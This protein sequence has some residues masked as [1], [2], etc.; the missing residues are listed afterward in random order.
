L[1]VLVVPMRVRLSRKLANRLDGI[2]VSRDP[3]GALLDLPVRQAELL[4]AE[5]WATPAERR[6]LSV[7]TPREAAGDHQ[8]RRRSDVSERRRADGR[9]GDEVP[10]TVVT[11]PRPRDNKSR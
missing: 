4:I 5:G 2:D 6:G 9:V 3:E 1:C 8:R 7:S 11:A 10:D